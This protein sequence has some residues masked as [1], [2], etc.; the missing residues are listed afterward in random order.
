MAKLI[1]VLTAWSVF[2]VHDTS[3]GR[4]RDQ[5]VMSY[6]AFYGDLSLAMSCLPCF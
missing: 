5:D 1:E 3:Q 4:V 6:S 2:T